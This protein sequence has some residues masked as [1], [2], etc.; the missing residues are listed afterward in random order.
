MDTSRA[1]EANTQRR[2]TPRDF[3]IQSL[4]E[5]RIFQQTKRTQ[6]ES[7]LRLNPQ[8]YNQWVQY[9]QF[10]ANQH[11]MR[12]AR[13]V[14]ERG[15][16]YASGRDV[17]LW[18]FY[19]Q[20]ETKHNFISH[21]RNLL[22]RATTV[23]PNVSK[24][25]FTWLAL[26]ERVVGGESCRRIYEAWLKVDQEETVW[27][28]YVDL[29]TR[30]GSYIEA[31]L[32][33]QRF[34]K[35]HPISGWKKW[36]AFELVNGD[37]IN[38]R[39]AHSLAVNTLYRQGILHIDFVQKW[40][41]WELKH[42][43]MIHVNRLL[44]FGDDVFGSQF[45]AFK[46]KAS[47]LMG[48]AADTSPVEMLDCQLKLNPS[49]YS[50]WWD[51]IQLTKPSMEMLA[52]IPLPQSHTGWIQYL[53]LQLYT[54]FALEL[55]GV[56]VKEQ[57]ENLVGMLPQEYTFV[58]V[59]TSF[60][61]H[62]FRSGDISAMRMFYGKIIG[63]RP[64]P[65][66]VKHYISV[67][68]RLGN[69]KRVRLLY[70]KM[71]DL[72]PMNADIWSEYIQWESRWGDINSM[73]TK[74]LESEEFDLEFKRLLGTKLEEVLD[75]ET[76]LNCWDLIADNGDVSDI[77]NRCLLAVK[78]DQNVEVV[79]KTFKMYLTLVDFSAKLKLLK[80]WK[81]VEDGVW[82]NEEGAAYVEGLIE[83]LTNES[84]D[85][86]EEE[87]EE[88]GEDREETD[89]SQLEDYVREDQEVSE[90]DAFEAS[91]SDIATSRSFASR[92]AADSDSE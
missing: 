59:W 80:T 82:K 75:N 91:D 40:I 8:N 51:Y 12:R 7:S 45:S 11:N 31:R 16:E 54:L 37:E 52:R 68:E 88:K 61:D 55:E 18:F 65:R 6:F 4:Q 78:F 73:V 5:L 66:L 29:E 76:V 24:L 84:E 87:P 1:Y 25:W 49:D 26:E 47:R 20:L 92:F 46:V 3:T 74:V 57:Y 33:C 90:G 21:A 77:V 70:Q 50:S 23:L 27:S 19:I 60:G 41:E 89:D 17:K 10:E 28:N 14:L 72:W 81:R 35:I 53:H 71:L 79:R 34:V 62:L 32:V 83:E 85:E 67:E 13:S 58:I 38:I 22:K 30:L 63:T 43:N 2:Q 39:N 44:Q 15:I 42:S 56:P 86:K 48:S 64:H 9:A 69:R 36:I